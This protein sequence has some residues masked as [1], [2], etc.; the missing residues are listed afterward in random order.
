MLKPAADLPIRHALEVRHASFE[1]PEFI[2][3]LREHHVAIVV[4]DSAGKWPI[5]EDVTADF[6]YIRLHG[7][8]FWVP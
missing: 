4:A 7:V 8:V 6:I 1:Q 3:Q 5:I 2:S